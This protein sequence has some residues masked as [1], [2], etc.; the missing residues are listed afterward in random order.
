[1]DRVLQPSTAKINC[2]ICTRCRSTIDA[3]SIYKTCQLCREKDRVR[4]EKSQIKKDMQHL[5]QFRSYHE[6]DATSASMKERQENAAPHDGNRKFITSVKRKA[7][8][9]LYELEAEERM[10]ALKMAKKSLTEIVQR[11]GKKPMPAVQVNSVGMTFRISFR[12]NNEFSYFINRATLD[13]Q[14]SRI[15]KCQL[16]LRRFEVESPLLLPCS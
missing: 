12:F 7:Q 2:G 14:R 5:G 4:R 8:K 6:D 13:Q 10:V 9:S 3:R 15:S 16:T 1:M 11:Q